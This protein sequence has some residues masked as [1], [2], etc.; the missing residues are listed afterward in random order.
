MR[1]DDYYLPHPDLDGESF[2]ILHPIFIFFTLGVWLVFQRYQSMRN[3][4]VPFHVR[5][6]EVRCFIDTS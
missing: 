4:S 1:D 5:A 2:G 3:W 6:L